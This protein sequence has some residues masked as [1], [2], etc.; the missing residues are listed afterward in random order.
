VADR[1][2]GRGR[3]FSRAIRGDGLVARR[4]RRRCVVSRVARVCA[5]VYHPAGRGAPRGASA[6]P[7]PYREMK[8]VVALT[9]VAVLAAAVRDSMQGV[10]PADSVRAALDRLIGSGGT[11]R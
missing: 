6:N 7:S 11:P 3:R 5:A 2:R 4:H 1:R 8:R 10:V 9:V